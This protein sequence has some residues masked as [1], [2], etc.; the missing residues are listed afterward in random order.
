MKIL[1]ITFL[2]FLFL[3]VSIYGG[4]HFLA[5]KVQQES[6]FI[7]QINYYVQTSK[8]LHTLCMLDYMIN[9]NGKDML[10]E[11]KKLTPIITNKEEESLTPYYDFYKKYLQW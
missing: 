5:Y 3:S 1:K 10:E 2:F 6:K 7:H 11:C 9:P 4:F 8:D